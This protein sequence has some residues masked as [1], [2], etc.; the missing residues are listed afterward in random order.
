[1]TDVG[2]VGTAPRTSDA[3]VD[4][5]I[6]ARDVRRVF[7]QEL[8]LNRLDLA[9]PR[10]I[11]YGFVGPSG[12]GKTTAV[13]IL[14]GID[15][16]TD[17]TV[18]VL[19]RPLGRFDAQLRRRI[20]YMPQ[21]SV[22][23]PNLSARENL[24]FVAS[25]YGLPLRRGR[26]LDDVL[27]RTELY[28]H[29]KKPVRELS[30]G[31]RRRLALSAALVH[32]P[33]VLFLDEPTAGIDPVLRRQ[34]WS[35]LEELRDAG[36][37]LFVTTQYVSEAAYCDLVGVLSDGRLI[38]EDSPE[39]LRQQALGGDVIELTPT[40]PFAEETMAELRQL[41][42]VRQVRRAGD[43]LRIRIVVD[44]ADRRLAQIQ[45]WCARRELRVDSVRE[46]HVSFDDVFAILMG[47]DSSDLPTNGDGR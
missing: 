38:A 13:R 32:E 17:G 8:A 40:V 22:H 37:T 30:G 19:G 15:R 47:D 3:E 25:L 4:M 16:P 28:E 33:E 23:F 27:R 21:E 26:I 12:S 7:G 44:A 41:E 45:D 36:R 10:G 35:W 39:G 31:M 1:M 24:S 18:S 20:G 43:G 34:L 14:T 5:V 46:H 29:R 2:E 11:I 6:S 42:G 9:V